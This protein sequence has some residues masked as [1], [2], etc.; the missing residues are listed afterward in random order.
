MKHIACV[1][2]LLCLVSCNSDFIC[3]DSRVQG[4]ST[5]DEFDKYKSCEQLAFEFHDA[6]LH[7][8]DT[9]LKQAQSQMFAK[10]PACWL[11]TKFT[12][13]SAEYH[14][15]GRMQYL[16]GMY[17]YKGCGASLMDDL[18]IANMPKSIAHEKYAIEKGSDVLVMK[19]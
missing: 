18:E 10:D 9:I 7:T 8:L 14:A 3:P 2:S 1:L 12:A 5:I 13:K 11:V 15:W 4:L 17:Q 6:R 19:H 16:N